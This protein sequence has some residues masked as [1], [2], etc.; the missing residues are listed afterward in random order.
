MKKNP[1][2]RERRMLARANRRHEG[3]IKSRLNEIKT[4]NA[5][6]SGSK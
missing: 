1:G 3:R 2:R 5:A 6:R 4:K